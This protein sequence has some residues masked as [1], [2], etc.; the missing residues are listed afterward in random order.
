MS[1]PGAAGRPAEA[2]PGAGDGGQVLFGGEDLVQAT[3]ARL[4][5]IRGADIAMIFQDALT[6]L[7]PLHRVGDQIAEMIR[8]HEPLGRAAARRRAVLLITHDFGVV[9]AVAGPGE[10]AVACHHAERLE[11]AT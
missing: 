7:H 2:G 6:G 3:P 1:A 10:V 9:A 5:E 4:R 11:A 8:A